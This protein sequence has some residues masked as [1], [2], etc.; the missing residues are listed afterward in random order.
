MRLRQK[1]EEETLELKISIHLN[2]FNRERTVKAEEIML[3]FKHKGKGLETFQKAEREE[4]ERAIKQDI[5]KNK[6]FGKTKYKSR[7]MPKNYI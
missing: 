6:G 5:Q 1:N 7:S 2:K 4:Y 3:K